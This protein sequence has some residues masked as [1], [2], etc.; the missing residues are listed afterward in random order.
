MTID[1]N[2][3]LVEKDL[4]L[5]NLKLEL[6][7][8]KDF[9]PNFKV[10]KPNYLYPTHSIK[11]LSLNDEDGE[12]AYFTDLKRVLDYAVTNGRVPKDWLLESAPEYLVKLAE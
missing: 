4:E 1:N 3:K 9:S 8:E 6:L 11:I 10:T 5:V 7:A 12:F 2:I